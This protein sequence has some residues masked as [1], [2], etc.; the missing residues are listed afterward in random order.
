MADLRGVIGLALIWLAL[1]LS[2]ATWLMRRQAG[3]FDFE[4]ETPPSWS[5]S[6][7]ALALGAVLACVVGA[8]LIVVDAA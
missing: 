6:Q 5:L 2:L 3:A 4:R 1:I 7:R 8:I